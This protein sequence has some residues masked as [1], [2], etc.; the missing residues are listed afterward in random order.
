[1]CVLF[2][3]YLPCCIVCIVIDFKKAFDSVHRESIWE[4]LK[5]YG[6][7]HKIINIF[8]SLY[9]NSR[10]CIRTKDGYSDMFDIITGVR[11]GCILSPFLFLIVMDFIM[12]KSMSKPHY[13]ISWSPG[14]L[15]ATIALA[16]YSVKR[17]RKRAKRFWMRSLFQRRHERGA[18]N[19]LMAELRH[20]DIGGDATYSGFT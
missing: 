2:Y 9:T 17:R 10:C 3:F 6:I 1:M 4:I 15:T 16:A 11:Q 5:L 12:R 13:G 8:I 14:R 19:T 18:Y 20:M 7:L